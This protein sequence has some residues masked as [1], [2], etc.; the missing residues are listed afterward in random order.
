MLPLPQ[1]SSRNPLF[2]ASRRFGLAPKVGEALD[3]NA[4]TSAPDKDQPVGGQ[5]LLNRDIFAVKAFAD[6]LNASP[7]ANLPEGP[8]SPG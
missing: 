3:S 1:V 4:D 8:Y 7:L 6:D 5:L 2:K